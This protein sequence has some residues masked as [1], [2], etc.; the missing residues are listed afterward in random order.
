MVAI[1]DDYHHQGPQRRKR[2]LEGLD[3][4]GLLRSDDRQSRLVP[5]LLPRY[6]RFVT[7]ASLFSGKTHVFIAK[8]PEKDRK[9]KLVTWTGADAKDYAAIAKKV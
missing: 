2:F 3:R 5:V 1:A 7:P 4:S 8:L 6:C 9:A